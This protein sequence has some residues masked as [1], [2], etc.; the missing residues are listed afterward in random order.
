MERLDHREQIKFER[1]ELVDVEEVG[2]LSS[3]GLKAVRAVKG[4]LANTR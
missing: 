4:G 1:R 3:L 2:E